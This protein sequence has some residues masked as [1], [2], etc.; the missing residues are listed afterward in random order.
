MNACPPQHAALVRM[1]QGSARQQ[2]AHQLS[3]PWQ[4]WTNGEARVTCTAAVAA[5][6]A[7]DGDISEH[8]VNA[9][10]SCGVDQP[11]DDEA[12]RRERCIR[13]GAQQCARR[14]DAKQL[15]LECSTACV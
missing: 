12:L 7:V 15:G 10:L 2:N 9:V 1:Q 11:V 6:A 14:I 8:S 4:R 5:A 13:G 3:G